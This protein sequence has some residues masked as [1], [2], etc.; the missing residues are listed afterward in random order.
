M[1]NDQLP[2]IGDRIYNAEL[3][4]MGFPPDIRFPKQRLA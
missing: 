4:P 3:V 1:F 2:K